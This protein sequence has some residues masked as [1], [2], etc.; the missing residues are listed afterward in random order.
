M[1]VR[2]MRAGESDFEQGPVSVF[3]GPTLQGG[4]FFTSQKVVMEAHLSCQACDVAWSR[5]LHQAQECCIWKEGLSLSLSLG[6]FS[7]F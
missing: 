6:H 2:E 7:L 3:F 1:H 5:L 4:F